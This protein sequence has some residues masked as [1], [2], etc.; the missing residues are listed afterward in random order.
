MEI[1]HKLRHFA[2]ILLIISAFTHVL[3]LFYFGFDWHQ[4]VAA[5]WGS[6][7]LVIGLL[8]IYLKK[9]KF[10]LIFIVIILTI[11]GT[12]GI[13]RFILILTTENVFNYFNLFHPIVDAI[14]VPICIYLYSKLREEE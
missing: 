3:Q 13:I 1:E 9:N 4:I 10:I 14:V 8:L 2:G 5:V 7:Y 12:Y 6:F 11:G